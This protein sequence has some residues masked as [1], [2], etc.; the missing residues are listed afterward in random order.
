M[1]RKAILTP[2][3]VLCAL[4]LLLVAGL[5][6][7][8]QSPA[9]V[10]RLASA[11][12][13]YTGYRV[14]IQNISFNRHLETRIQGLEVK[15]LQGNRFYLAASDAEVKG[16]IDTSLKVEVEKIILTHP[17][18]TFQVRKEKEEPGLFAAIA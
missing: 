1:R 18:F 2:L 7:L 17:R 8:V 14:H 6:F 3:A 11:L 4:L 12:E 15:G 13:P 16:K 5:F 10:N 9:S